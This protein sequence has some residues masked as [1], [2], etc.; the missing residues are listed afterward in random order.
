LV[1]DVVFKAGELFHTLLQLVN[2]RLDR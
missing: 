1:V 2:A